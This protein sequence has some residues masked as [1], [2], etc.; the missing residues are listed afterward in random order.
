MLT[1]RTEKDGSEFDFTR[2]IVTV[3]GEQFVFATLHDAWAFIL[4]QR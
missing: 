4:A 1:F 2:H 3:N